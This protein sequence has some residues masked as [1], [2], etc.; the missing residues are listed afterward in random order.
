MSP[1]ETPP[2]TPGTRKKPRYFYGWNVVFASFMAHLAYSEHFSST[3]GLFMTSF[4]KEFGWSRTAVA[5]VQT[6]ARLCEAIVAPIAGP[7]VD[8]FGPRPLIPLGG[9]IVGLV[10]LAV[11]QVTSLWQFY[12]FRGV[13]MAIG[14]TLMGQLVTNVAINNWFIRKRGRA[15][16]LANSGSNVGNVAMIPIIV[17][18]IAAYGWRTPFLVY[19]LLTF[20]VVIIPSAI[21]MRRRPEEMGLH[22]DGVDPAVAGS[23]T[24][25]E[26][27]K[28]TSAK[29]TIGGPEPLWNRREVLTTTAFWMLAGSFAIDN[30]A[31]QGIN[32]SL[33]PYIEDLGYGETMKASVVTF[34]AIIMALMLPVMGF[35]AEYAYKVRIR[36]F[37]F[38]LLG[39]GS[40]LFLLAGTPAFLWLAVGV[41]GLGLT[42]VGVVQE[43]VWAN[44]FGRMS[45]GLVRSTAYFVAFGLGSVGPIFMNAIFDILG[46]YRPAYILFIGLFIIAGFMMGIAKPPTARRYAT[47]EETA[48]PS[49]T[50]PS[51]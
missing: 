39:L 12:A 34:R 19:A 8:R 16:G 6:I 1:D 20:A 44:F 11:P 24:P 40:F 13:V 51:S 10:M 17:W 42:S 15:L 25:A 32:I 3:L 22:P 2:A 38:V 43:V 47:A 14:F 28:E 27:K 49:P 37:P 36:V 31:F 35:L 9:L 33:A 30:L 23:T 45:L 4:K 7:L 46:S 41:Y 50:E 26:G 5:A 21:L 29:P 48:P 18:L